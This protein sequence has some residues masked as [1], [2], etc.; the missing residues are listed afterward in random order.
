MYDSLWDWG[1]GYLIVK[2]PCMTIFVFFQLQ[3]SPSKKRQ[4]DEIRVL[5]L[6]LMQ[7]LWGYI[8]LVLQDVGLELQKSFGVLDKH[9]PASGIVKVDLPS[10][11]YH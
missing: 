1:V 10:M 5:C 7:S 4:M 6:L 9:M 3:A 2:Q 8:L 11:V